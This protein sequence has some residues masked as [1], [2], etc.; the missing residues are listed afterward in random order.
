MQSRE[1]FMYNLLTHIPT[2]SGARLL[3]LI[4]NRSQQMWLHEVMTMMTQEEGKKSPTTLCCPEITNAVRRVMGRR[5]STE[6][7]G[8]VSFS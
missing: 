8:I 5:L 1:P 4:T 2:R 7:K 6:M 3:L